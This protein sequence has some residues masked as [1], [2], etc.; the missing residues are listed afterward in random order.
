MSERQARRL[1][2]V[3]PLESVEALADLGDVVLFLGSSAHRRIVPAEGVEPVEELG[4]DR[5]VESL[6]L[7]LHMLDMA[8]EGRGVRRAIG[9][10]RQPGPQVR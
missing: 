10:G 4:I 7:P 9:R 8:G 2:C 3:G 1:D 6:E 5:V